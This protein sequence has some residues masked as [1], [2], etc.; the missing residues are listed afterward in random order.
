MRK[1]AYAANTHIRRIIKVADD[2][3]FAAIHAHFRPD[4]TIVLSKAPPPEGSADEF[5]LW[6]DRL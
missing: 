6:D 2:A 5:R 4:G 3:G 1:R